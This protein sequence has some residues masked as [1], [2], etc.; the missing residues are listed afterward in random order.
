METRNSC[1]TE[2][3]LLVKKPMHGFNW[4][5]EGLHDAAPAP[6]MGTALHRAQDHALPRHLS[7]HSGLVP[8]WVQTA[9]GCCCPQAGGRSLAPPA[10]GEARAAGAMA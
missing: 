2:S 7:Q 3:S 5:E 6:G 10:G 1:K 8:P 9:I 4:Q